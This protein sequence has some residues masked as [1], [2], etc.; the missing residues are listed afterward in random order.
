[1]DAAI[2][3]GNSGGPLVNL[4]GEIV[5]IN[6]AIFSTSGGYQGIGFAI[7]VNNAK[8][9]ISRLI[10]GKKIIYGWVGVT[11]QDLNEELAQYFGFA[12][13]NGVLVANVMKDGPAGQA[14]IMERD[15]ITE[16]DRKPI[17]NV[18]ELLAEVAKTEVG[19]KVKVGIVREE[20]QMV[21]EVEIGER[22]EDFDQE[23]QESVISEVGSWRGLEVQELSTDA[24]QRVRIQED[25]GVVVVAVEPNSLA[26][27]AG[28]L[29]GD[30]IIEINRTPIRDLH[31]YQQVV[32]GLS[33][34]VLVRTSRGYCLVK[35]EE[36]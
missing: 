13:R 17:K 23:I 6:V 14:G 35:G 30:V 7:P 8:R 31:S 28:I 33:G 2:N 3:P 25:S 5:G 27:E 11:V 12:N 36:E 20:R 21:L 18:R 34:S 32:E 10:E 24:S 9:I 1:T 4:K 29:P 15:I 19:R 16:F 26:E 22:P